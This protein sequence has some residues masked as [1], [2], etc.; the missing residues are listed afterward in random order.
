MDAIEWNESYSVGVAELDEQHKGLFKII[1]TI[2]ESDDLSVNSQ[3]ITDL[4]SKMAKY[5]TAHFDVEEKYMSECD[6]PDI[7]SH[8]RAHDTFRKKVDELRLAQKAENKNMPSDMSRFLYEWLVNHI[9]F[10]DKKYEPYIT[11]HNSD[12][13]DKKQTT[14]ALNDTNP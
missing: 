5:T 8:I 2:F 7:A 12:N 4:L 14:A 11:G 6:Y 10:C 9:M 1:N 3:T 13:A